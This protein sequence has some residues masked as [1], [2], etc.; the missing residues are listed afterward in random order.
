MK[1]IL[2]VIP[3]SLSK[4]SIEKLEKDEFI[5][6]EHP[7]PNEVRIITSLD[8]IEGNDFIVALIKAIDGG[9]NEFYYYLSNKLY[10]KA[11]KKV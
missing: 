4:A 1:Q 2:V 3:G 11:S 6:I 9:K 10:E 5:I 8:G 7:K